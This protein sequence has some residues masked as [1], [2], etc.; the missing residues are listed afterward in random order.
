MEQEYERAD[1]LALLA[2]LDVRTGHV[3]AASTGIAPF[4]TPMGPGHEPRDI[5]PRAP[6]IRH[7]GQRLRPPRRQGYPALGF[8]PERSMHIIR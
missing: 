8:P 7:R 3:F 5:P 6:G 1:A 4:M 2:A